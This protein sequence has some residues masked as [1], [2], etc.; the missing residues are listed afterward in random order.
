MKYSYNWL[1]ELSG[2]KKSTE[3]VAELFLTHSFEVEGIE[4]LAKGLDNVVI[5][6]VLEVEKHPD[7]DRLNIAKV[8]VGEKN[9]GELQIVCGAPNLK[10]GQKVPVALV[11]AKIRPIIKTPTD[12]KE[13]FKI[14]KSKIRGIESNGMICA[15]DELGLGEE[16]EGIMILTESAKV[17][18]DFSEYMQLKDKVLDIDILPNRGHDCLSYNGVARELQALENRKI[19]DTRYK[20][21][22]NLKSQI[23]NDDSLKVEIQTLNCSR[24][25]GIRIKNIEIKESPQW[26]RARLKASGIKSINNIVDITNYVMLETNQPLHAFDSQTLN[27][28]CRK[29]LDKIVVRQA[30]EEEKIVLLDEQEL[31][32]TKEDIV[33][34][35]GQKPIALAGV[36]GGLDSGVQDSTTEIILEGANFNPTSIRFTARKYNLLSDAAYRFERDIDPNFIDIAINRATE[37]IKEL[38]GGEVDSITDTYPELVE[39]WRINLD[40]KHVRKLLGV[41]IEDGEIKSILERLGIRVESQKSKVKS[42]LNC[43]IPTRRRD[44]RTAEDLIEEIGRIY[45][46][47][48]IQPEPIQ[49]PIQTP[50]RNEQRFFERKLKGIAVKSG[51]SEIRGYSFYSQADADALGLG[52]IRHISLL[53]PASPE[54]AIL[55]NTLTPSLLKANR[56]SL[57][58]FK[59]VR[60]FE[61]G[62]IYKDRG[63]TLPQEELYFGGTVVTKENN[64]EQ[65]YELKGLIDNLLESFGIS[66]CYYDPNFDEDENG[67]LPDL[68]PSRR[69]LIKNSEG[70][71]IGWLGE[72]S[73]KA[74]KYFGLKNVRGALCEI[75]IDRLRNQI[76]KATAYQPLSKFPFVERDL[77]MIV[78]EK[79]R[80]GEVEDVLYKAG[81]KLLQDV[82]LFD[83][84]QNK[85]TGERSMAFHLMFGDKEKTLQAKEVDDKIGEIIKVVEN[86]LNVEV[87]K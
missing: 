53:N 40:L 13:I 55:R 62:R 49:A 58:Y 48:K 19:Q 25:A 30:E 59:E 35:D 16:H 80:V 14:K 27:V 74:S 38:A 20:Q 12:K 17:G 68:H 65:F 9:G 50:H 76:K 64:G 69:A 1:K 2:T 71:I 52:E 32:L 5:G 84:Y 44:L 33:I 87:K 22:S 11:G 34:T 56:K 57:S 85:E 4:D 6:E 3:E 31:E 45:G 7:A 70:E 67:K 75:N 78:G 51:F 39:P 36:M 41:Q 37:L 72:I 79:L 23:S 15:E 46:Y 54:Q 82:D 18:Q 60:V 47:S 24:Y 83:L 77:S 21:I 8:N 81:G 10:V 28:E 86:E 61:V 42:R 66:D 63:E 29:S 26:M 73:K 43:I